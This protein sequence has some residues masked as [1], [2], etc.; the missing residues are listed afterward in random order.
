LPSFSRIVGSSASRYRSFWR[1]LPELQRTDGQIAG[2]NAV[3]CGATHSVMERCNFSCTSCY[4]SEAAQATEPAAFDE[5]CQQ[6]NE[7]RAWLGPGGKCQITSGEVALLPVEALGRIVTYARRIGLDP[8]VMTNGERLLDDPDYLTTLVRDYGLRKVSFHVDTTQR[9]RPGWRPEQTEA[10]LH[11]LRDRFADLVRRTRR[12]TGQ[13][14][15]A[16]MTMTVTGA[17]AHGVADV[18]D[19]CLDNADAM[20]LVSFL[21]VAPVGRTK[22]ESDDYLDLGGVW[23]RICRGAGRLLNRDALR[24]GHGECNITAP[25][26]VL[27]AGTRRHVVEVVRAGKG[28]DRRI[29]RRALREF[30]PTLHVDEGF[31]RTVT[32][33]VAGLL[34]R[35]LALL[36]LAAYGL[37]R[38]WTERATLG[39]IVR[40]VCTRGQVQLRPQLLVVHRFMGAEE[41]DTDLGRERLQSCVFRVPVDGEMVSMCEVNAGD[42]RRRLNE[43]LTRPSVIHNRAVVQ[44]R[45]AES[46]RDSARSR[47]A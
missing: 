1:A 4:L 26:V 29:M 12:Q 15:H 2:V 36:E 30:A 28:W 5:V 7:L 32:R 3:G 11:P 38:G 9:G 16:A 6:L 21:P 40:A 20:R 46:L 47:Y 25:V 19:W 13:I 35:P 23:Q 37:Y 24:F 14:L 44:A 45:R 17:N 27:R 39:A 22:D 34:R 10:E 31:L 8:M 41:I 42:I 43:R 33:V 18:I